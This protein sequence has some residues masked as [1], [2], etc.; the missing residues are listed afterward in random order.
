MVEIGTRDPW[1]V[2]RGMEAWVLLASV[3][4]VFSRLL[5]SLFAVNGVV[6]DAFNP[7]FQVASMHMVGAFVSPL[8][9]GTCQFLYSSAVRSVEH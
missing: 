6:L 7:I 8:D 3:W 5:C 9:T 2:A 4:E 1:S